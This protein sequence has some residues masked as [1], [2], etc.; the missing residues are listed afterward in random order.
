MKFNSDKFEF[1]KI[2]SSIKQVSLL[3][4]DDNFIEYGL[5]FNQPMEY[6]GLSW[7]IKDDDQPET[8]KLNIIHEVDNIAK[9]W[10][11][12]KIKDIESWL[13]TDDFAPFISDDDKT[14]TYYLKTVNIV[15]RFD[16]NMTGWLEVEFQ[17][18]SNNG[19][20]NQNITLR[21]PTRFLKMKNIPVM[22][23]VNEGDSNKPYY[24]IIKITG[25]NGELRIINQTNKNTF[26]INSTGN[27]R[28]DNKMGTIFDDNGNN[29]IMYSN[30]KW[31]FFNKGTNQIQVIG[32]CKSISF[33][34]QYEVGI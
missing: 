7:K 1:N 8:I 28:I 10:T 27:I 3:W 34:S 33:I 32:D 30:R 5:N 31:V 21:N 20:I 16:E 17:P 6:D 9:V 4:G 19:Y 12:E 11:K 15:R 13:K 29:L 24:P 14:I 25:L 2:H 22:S 23:I 26:T 18:L